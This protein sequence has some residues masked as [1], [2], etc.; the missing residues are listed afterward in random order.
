MISITDET[1]WCALVVPFP[2][3]DASGHLPSGADLPE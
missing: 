3:A 1:L 2:K